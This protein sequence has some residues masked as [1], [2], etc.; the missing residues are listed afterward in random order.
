MALALWMSISTLI[1]FNCLTSFS[2]PVCSLIWAAFLFKD[3]WNRLLARS[4]SSSFFFKSILGLID[5]NNSD[6]RGSALEVTSSNCCFTSLFSSNKS[7]ITLSE[8]SNLD[9]ARFALVFAFACD[10]FAQLRQTFK[11]LSSINRFLFCC[12]N[13]AIANSV[14]QTDAVNWVSGWKSELS[15]SVCIPLDVVPVELDRLELGVVH[16]GSVWLDEILRKYEKDGL[17]KTELGSTWKA[18]TT[19]KGALIRVFK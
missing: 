11:L 7:E 9:S 4:Y 8:I 13:S 12:S 3:S 16:L 15:G 10:L 5:S 14:S 18:V 17:L 2:I 1:T 6:W 19:P